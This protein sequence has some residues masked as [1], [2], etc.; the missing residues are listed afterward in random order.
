MN[1]WKEQK[2]KVDKYNLQA[3]KIVKE[4]IAKHIEVEISSI[5]KDQNEATDLVIKRKKEDVALRIRSEHV[6]KKEWTVRSSLDSG[7][8]TELNK[9]RKGFTRWYLYGWAKGD[10]IESWIFID[11]DIVRE[12]NILNMDWSEK[13]NKN[14]FGESDGTHYISI[15]IKY[16]KDNGCI[17]SLHNITFEDSKEL[18]ITSEKNDNKVFWKDNKYHNLPKVL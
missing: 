16:L 18:E 10:T 14:E 8:E 17:D 9:I 1:N 2:D 12:K 4:C 3:I 15:P 11:L 6:W 7:H 5:Y 13:N